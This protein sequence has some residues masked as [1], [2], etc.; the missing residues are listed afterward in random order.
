MPDSFTSEVISEEERV[1]AEPWDYGHADLVCN[2]FLQRG[3][4]FSEVN[5]AYLL[6]ELA[7]REDL[8]LTWEISTKMDYL[9]LQTTFL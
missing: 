9:V 1:D 7:N 6:A 5:Q 4:P 8:L 3:Y 2:R